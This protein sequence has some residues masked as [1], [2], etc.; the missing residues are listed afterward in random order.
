MGFY[1][2]DRT[3]QMGVLAVVA[4]LALVTTAV[5]TG[6]EEVVH[7]QDFSVGTSRSD[8]GRFTL[9]AGDYQ[10]WFDNKFDDQLEGEYMWYCMYGDDGPIDENET[11]VDEN[12]V[13][14]MTMDGEEYELMSTF[15][16]N[17]EEDI[18][19]VGDVDRT[20][21]WGREGHMVFIRKEPGNLPMA[22]MGMAVLSLGI[23]TIT[24]RN[25]RMRRR[26]ASPA[27]QETA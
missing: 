19:M 15:T 20:W 17:R 21:G 6:S 22:L 14:Y 18:H 10:L 7:E 4:G 5:L 3:V 2:L 12:L 25:V 26:D 1:D 24:M 13:R 11:G 27:P 23:I 16:L 9:P 8:M